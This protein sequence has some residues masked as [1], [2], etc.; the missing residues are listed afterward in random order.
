MGGSKPAGTQL[1]FEIMKSWKKWWMIFVY[2]LDKNQ[3]LEMRKVGKYMKKRNLTKIWKMKKWGKKNGINPKI[4]I[5]IFLIYFISKILNPFSC[6]T[7][8]LNIQ[9]YSK[10]ES[11]KFLKIGLCLVILPLFFLNQFQRRVMSLLFFKCSNHHFVKSDLQTIE[12]D[13]LSIPFLA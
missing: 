7:T 8:D 10:S 2:S 9:R 6:P 13:Q 5:I 1:F 4:E 11:A 12:P 3:S